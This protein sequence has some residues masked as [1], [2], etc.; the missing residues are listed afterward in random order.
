[1]LQTKVTEEL[2]TRLFIQRLVV[3]WEL[4]W[5]EFLEACVNTQRHIAVAA[6]HVCAGHVLPCVALSEPPSCSSNRQMFP[7]FS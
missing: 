3:T 1:M 4:L 5:M 7:N 2:E 6:H